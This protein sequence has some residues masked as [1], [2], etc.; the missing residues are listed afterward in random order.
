MNLQL[1]TD[2]DNIQRGYAEPG[3]KC[4]VNDW[5]GEEEARKG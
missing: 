2:L 5:L 3:A 1:Q 4:L